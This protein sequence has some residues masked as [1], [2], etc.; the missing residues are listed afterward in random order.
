M[1]S[2]ICG[3]RWDDSPP[4]TEIVRRGFDSQLHGI[5]CDR[6]GASWPLMGFQECLCLDVDGEG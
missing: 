2:S 4:G 5:L 6:G 1:I 3:Y